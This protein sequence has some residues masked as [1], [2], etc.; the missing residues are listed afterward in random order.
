M[1]RESIGGIKPRRPFPMIVET[2]RLPADSSTSCQL[3]H[4]CARIGGV[5]QG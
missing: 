4:G 5:T 3:V 1:N 2:S